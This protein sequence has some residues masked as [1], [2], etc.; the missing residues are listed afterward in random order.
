MKSMRQRLLASSMICGAALL[1]TQAQAQGANEVQE[2]VV[3]GSRIPQPN[4]TSIS[5]V[6]SINASDIRAQGVT[7]I[8]D[9]INSL[10]Q[11]FASQGAFISNGA[12]GTAT[13]NLRGL[14]SSRTLVLVDGRRIMPGDPGSSAADLNFIPSALV[15]RVE[16]LTGGA[17]STYGADAVSGVVNFLMQRNFEGFKVD[18]QYST[19]QHKNDN[20]GIQAIIKAKQA[21]ATDKSQFVVPSSN[22]T[23]GDGVA[24]SVAFGANTSDD[25]GNITAYATWRYNNPILQGNRDYSTCT[26]FS[27]DAFT[28][29]GSGTASPARFGS[30]VVDPSGPGNTFRARNSATDVYNYGPTNY[31]QRPDER[32]NLGAFAHYD[33]TEWATAYMDVMFMDDRSVAQIAPGG[34]FAGSYSVNCDNPLMTAAQQTQLC[35]ATAGTATLKSLTVAK[36]NVEGG[37]RQSDIRHNAYRIVLGLKGDLSDAW[38]YD[39]YLQYGTATTSETRTGYFLVPN[40]KNALVARRNSAGQI[41]CQSV[42]DGTDP[43]CVPYNI[44][45]LNGVTPAALNY[46]QTDSSGIGEL[47]QTVVSGSVTGQLGEYGVKSPFAEEGVGVAFGAEY[48]EESASSKSDYVAAKGLLSGTGG[49]SPPISGGFDVYELFGEARIPLVENLP[50]AQKV[51]LQVGYRYSDY[52]SQNTNTY[53]IEGDWDVIDGLRFRAG[54]NHAVRAPNI[55]NLFAP[56]NVVLDGTT[57]PC[58]GLS[59]SNPLVAKCAQAFSLTTAQVLAIEKN[60]APQ[61]NGLVGGNP[62]LKPEAADTYTVGV[63]YQPSFLPGFNASVDYFNIM[64]EDAIGSV[65]ADLAINRCLQSLDPFFCGL[66]KRD[67][68]GSLWLSNQG[69]IVD[70]TLNTG[71]VSTAGIDVNLSY[72][73]DL[74]DFGLDDYGSL[75]FDFVGTWLD[76]L[77]TSPLPGDPEYDCAGLYGTTCNG[78]NGPNPEWRHKFRVNWATPFWGDLQV[79]LQWRYFSE[80]T[81]DAFDSDPQL[82]SPDLQYPTDETLAAQSYFD[83]TASFKVKDNYTV[84]MGVNNVLDEDP[85]LVGG[86]ACPTGSCNGNTY[87][88]VYDAAGRYLF[89]G[90]KADF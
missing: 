36:R 27:G 56:Q 48:R 64:I 45:Q 33:V 3:T 31:Y 17:S 53:K 35:G 79:G 29:G 57:D 67:S 51:A 34:I 7:R 87:S 80:V 20:D 85:P 23:D 49:A 11:A 66:V 58:A 86:S 1:A 62:N 46:L 16:V 84:R 52:A 28:C 69:Y 54:Y 70:T 63:V 13:V 43:A 32:Y 76:S 83:L 21:T 50:L 71:S 39:T 40:I 82:N 15:E 72:R 55:S 14:G 88:Q 42:I 61:Y 24:V 6:T 2:V 65:G 75:S 8:E 81:L 90:L 22:V 78:G 44:Y 74:A 77:K 37:P 19:Y 68:Q 47:A 73:R 89:I 9:M 5:P 10:P 38:S 59:A 26:F 30:F 60:P 18:V 25:K 4:L 12:S 41:V